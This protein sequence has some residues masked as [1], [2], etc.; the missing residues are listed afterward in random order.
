VFK[1]KKIKEYIMKKAFTM[2]ELIF[3]IVIIGILVSVALPRLSLTRDDALIVRNTQYIVGIMIEVSTYSTTHG[4]SKDDLSEMSS[5][6]QVLKS[7]NRVIL[8]TTNKSA[9]IKIGN[10]ES[11]ITIDID[12]TPTT[13]WL[14]TVF[15]VNTTDRICHQVQEFIKEKDYPL[16][17]RG[18]LIKY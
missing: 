10:D 9:K 7:Q 16:V 11:C 2:I 13:D 6:L 1:N 15:S 14:K 4:E 5:L 3:V 18:R 12:T 17:L 8:D